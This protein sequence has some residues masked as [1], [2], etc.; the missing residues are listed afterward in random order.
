MKHFDTVIDNLLKMYKDPNTDYSSTSMFPT[1]NDLSFAISRLKDAQKVFLKQSIES[2]Q[3]T[4]ELWEAW[5]GLRD[6]IPSETA[7]NLAF[8]IIQNTPLSHSK[9]QMKKVE[10]MFYNTLK[11]F[12]DNEALA[13]AFTEFFFNNTETKMP[14]IK[15]WEK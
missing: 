9:Q 2:Q 7:S 1:A 10:D 5:L 8:C 11:S 3:F 15:D 4:P 14:K 13:K 6:E 12:S